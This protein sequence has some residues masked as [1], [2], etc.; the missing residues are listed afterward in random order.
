MPKKF[1]PLCKTFI[2]I[3]LK[4]FL[5]WNKCVN[6]KIIISLAPPT[7]ISKL[8]KTLQFCDRMEAMCSCILVL[9]TVPH[10]Q[11]NLVDVSQKVGFVYSY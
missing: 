10:M 5:V 2:D 1:L 9:I 3:I 11:S 4:L 8:G 6:H 7:F